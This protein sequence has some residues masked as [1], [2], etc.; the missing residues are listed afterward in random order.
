MEAL[1]AVLGNLTAIFTEMLEWVG[2]MYTFI[3]DKP[4]LLVMIVGFF[5]TGG[6]V[7]L[8]NRIMRG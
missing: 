7:G 8:F 1:T 5:L 3:I 6:V 2:Q 4:L